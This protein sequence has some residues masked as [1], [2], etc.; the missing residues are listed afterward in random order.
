M[1]ITR[2][3]VKWLEDEGYGTFGQNIFIGGVPLEAPDS[4]LWVLSAGGNVIS[5][6]SSGEKQK[7][8][9]FSVYIRDLDQQNLYNLLQQIEEE[10][11][12]KDCIELDGYEVLEVETIVF[13]TDQDLDNED[14]SIGLL[15]IAVTVYQNA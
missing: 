13:P 7:N 4:C 3:F 10:A 9:V 2:A 12:K 6:N 14:R 11:N 5:K 8:Y 15:Q 1:N